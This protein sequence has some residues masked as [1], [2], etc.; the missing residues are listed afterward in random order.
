MK[1][2]F[3]VFCKVYWPNCVVEDKKLT[4]GVVI[5]TPEK[6]ADYDT[7]STNCYNNNCCHYWSFNSRYQC[8]M[9]QKNESSDPIL[10]IDE[11]YVYYG[12]R[13]CFGKGKLK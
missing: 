3:H 8:T 12:H 5:G 4:G 7:C 2:P 13:D 1:Y 10:E 6:V 9:M 11:L